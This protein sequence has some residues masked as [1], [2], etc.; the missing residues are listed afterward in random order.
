MEGRRMK[1]NFKKL[2]FHKMALK[3]EPLIDDTTLRD[4]V[5]M[6]GL[7][8]S[9][10]DAA[11]IARLLDEIGVE[12]I[13]LHHFQQS[14]KKAARLIQDLSLNARVAG[15]CRAV[16]EDIDDAIDCGF[17][18]IGISH[19]VSHIHFKAKWPDKTEEDLLRRVVED[20][21]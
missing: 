21:E 1:L 7:A 14:D 11:E 17:E 8:V 4:G 13:E 15:W 6:P 19:P 2:H 18:E 12:R 16:K 5:Q 20:V 10:E 3:T 9:P